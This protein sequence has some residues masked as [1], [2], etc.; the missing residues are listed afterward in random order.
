MWNEEDFLFVEFG[1]RT[2]KNRSHTRVK[3]AIVG[4]QIFLSSSH[5]LHARFNTISVFRLLCERANNT[6]G[7]NSA[8]CF[9]C[10][11]VCAYCFFM[12]TWRAELN[13]SDMI[14]HSPALEQTPSTVNESKRNKRLIGCFHLLLISLMIQIL[15]DVGKMPSDN[16]NTLNNFCDKLRPNHASSARQIA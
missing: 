14:A 13:A 10:V 11:S 8:S 15:D 5:H 16:K 1:S 4:K 9:D 7:K 2:L 6:R 3:P 12:F